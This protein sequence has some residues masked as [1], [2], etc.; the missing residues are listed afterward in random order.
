MNEKTLAQISAELASVIIGQKFGKI[1]TLS[2][3]Q[4]A[5]DFRLP[6]SQF[7]FISIEPSAPRV[8]LIKRRLRDLEKQTTNQTSFVMF[9]RKRLAHAVLESVEKLASE[10]I[11]RLELSARDDLGEAVRYSLIIQLTGRSA[12][13]F[14]LNE[15]DQILDACRETRGA[16]QEIADGYAPPQMIGGNPRKQDD[17]TF[18]TG[19]FP[20]LSAALDDFYQ[21]QTAEK[22]FQAQAN[23]ARSKLKQELKKREKLSEKLTRDLN[24]HGDAESWKRF[25]DLILANLATARREADKVF[26]TDYYDENTPIIEIAIDD[27][28]SLT[29]AAERFFKKYTKARN[30]RIELTKRLADL[31]SQITDLQQQSA[32]VEAAIL[33]RDDDFLS[34]FSGERKIAP[35]KSKEKAADSFKGARQYYSSEGFEILVGKGAKD[36]DYLTFRLAKAADLWLHAADYPG[37]HVIIKNPNRIEIPPKTLLEAAQAAAFFSHAKAQ[38]KVA[39]HY[40]PKKFVNKPK[41]AGAGLVS[42]SSFKTILVEPKANFSEK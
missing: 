5:V 34:D 4:L 16:G 2:R 37:S 27:N 32:D 35:T 24:N 20:N 29:F 36:N 21:R 23:Q 40:T 1:F 28:D 15:N 13:L 31:E 8:Y 38:P 33:H 30:A 12:N 41:G 26:V 6:D 14:L 7:L 39:V 42:M 11:L 17:A 22:D 10:R 3:L 19:A 9:L 18:D 25:G